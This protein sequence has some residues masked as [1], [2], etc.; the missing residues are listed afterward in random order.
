MNFF[1]LDFLERMSTLLKEAFKFKKYKAMHPVLAVFTGILMLPIVAV[2]FMVTAMLAVL[3]FVFAFI[4]GP[5]KYLHEIVHGEGQ[6]VKHATQAIV[7]LISWPFVF[8]CYALIA[9]LLVLLIPTYALLSFLCYVWSLGGFKFHL[10]ANYTDDISITV[11]GRYRL[12][13]A[14]YVCVGGMLVFLI[15]FIHGIS[16]YAGSLSHYAGP[17]EVYMERLFAATFF[18]GIYPSYV[19]VHVAFTVLYTLIG[20]A[21]YPKKPAAVEAEVA[22]EE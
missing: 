16:H 15:P 19:W 8:F 3:G 9:F 11:E 17:D 6:S 18:S 5:V 4:T 14:I 13:P 7:Y 2:S 12:L 1:T 21:R 10:F 20:F 22:I